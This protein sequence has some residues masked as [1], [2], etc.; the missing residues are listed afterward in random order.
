MSAIGHPAR[1]SGSITGR[2]GA[3]IPAVSAMKWTPQKTIARASAAPP[4]GELQRVADEVGGVLDL[5]ALVVVG[6]DDGPRLTGQFA[7]LCVQL[8]VVHV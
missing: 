6:Q 3:R 4:A 7:Y 8:C 2:S 5:G 1:G